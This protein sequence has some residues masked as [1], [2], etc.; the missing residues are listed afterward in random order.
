MTDHSRST[1]ATIDEDEV[2]PPREDA[3]PTRP[4]RADARR[5]Y[6]KLVVAAHDVFAEEGGGASMDAI[7]KEA[8]VGVG[9]L[10]R[11]FP[12][13]IDLVEAVYRGDVDELVAAA[14]SA[15]GT[16]EP[17]PAMVA[18]LE[19]FIRYAAGKRRFLSELHEA[20][21]KN[22]DLRSESRERID[23]ALS[24]VLTR[25][26]DAG[27]VRDDLDGPD[28]MQLLGSM[29]MSATLTPEQSSR[30]L[31]VILDGLRPPK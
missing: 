29:C 23:G 30:L 28:L 17:W 20:F 12:R 31:V 27:V 8:G 21:E 1:T 7:A 26:Q 6:E 3:D 13:R 14:E 10:Y 9:T 2:V 15:V 19:A 18:Y 4:M 11:H 24:L 22:P 16:L 25:A 5:N